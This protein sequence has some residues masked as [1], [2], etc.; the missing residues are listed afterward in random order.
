MRRRIGPLLLVSILLCT[1]LQRFAGGEIAP[2]S[3]A[4]LQANSTDIVVGTVTARTITPDTS[5]PDW[6]NRAFLFTIEVEAVEKGDLAR[7]QEI[8]ASAWTSRWVGDGVPPPYGSGNRPLP[9]EGERAR[10]FLNGSTSGAMAILLPNG[11]ELVE[12]ANSANP[13]RFGDPAPPEPVVSEES[14]TTDPPSRDPFGWDIILLLLGLP[15]LIGA[16]RQQGGARWGLFVAACVLFAFAAIIA[17][18][19]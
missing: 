10:F 2:L 8:K 18:G 19:R 13:V 4:K 12:G 15:L 16:F 3:E 14:E 7:G 1:V 6:D 11:V 17:I 9:L 5:K